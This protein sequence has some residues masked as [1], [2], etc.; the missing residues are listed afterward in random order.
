MKRA[1]SF[2]LLA[3]AAGLIGG[4]EHRADATSRAQGAGPLAE[5]ACEPAPA[6]ASEVDLASLIERVRP[7]IVT[8]RA[9]RAPD[10][11]LGG[12][13]D[14]QQAVASGFILSDDGLVLTSDHVVEDTSA[15]QVRLADDRRFD[16]IVV[17]RDPRLDVALLKLQGSSALPVAALGSSAA[18]RVGDRAFVIGNPFGLGPSVTAGIVSATS[19]PI[20]PVPGGLIQTDAAINPGNSGGPLLNAAGEVVG[21][22]TAIH[23]EGRGIGF[24]VPIDD[25]RDVLPELR[26]TGHVERGRT[27][28][29]FQEVTDALA[30]ALK[31]PAR[32]GALVTDVEP[33]SPAAR[34]GLRPGDVITSIDGARIDHAREL[35]REIGRRKPGEEVAL[36]YFRGGEEGGATVRLDARGAPPPLPR[37]QAPPGAMGLSASDVPGGARIDGVDPRS[38]LVGDLEAGDVVL[39]VNGAPVGNAA[40]LAARLRGAPR[41]ADLLVRLRREG[42]PRFV[43]IRAP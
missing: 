21:V 17:G 19:R 30:R 10:P 12:A 22:T 14:A 31:L 16:A 25:I 18:V 11:A 41:G 34:A 24:A 15:I 1:T 42:S 2:G 35:A 33:R 40:G 27:G 13:A 5:A 28:L 3:L 4:C 32:A 7:S 37:P 39:E 8:V 36:A 6:P 20:G 23:A 26:A 29:G 38:A 9:S 43:A